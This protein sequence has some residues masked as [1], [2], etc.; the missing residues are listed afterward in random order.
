MMQDVIVHVPASLNLGKVIDF[1]VQVE[2]G[3][4]PVV[5]QSVETSTVVLCELA[6]DGLV[7]VSCHLAAPEMSSV[8]VKS[9]L[10]GTG[11]A[12]VSIEAGVR[13][14]A[15]MVGFV[16]S[17]TEVTAK[18]PGSFGRGPKPKGPKR[19]KLKAAS[20]RRA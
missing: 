18:V 10:T 1:A 12:V 11:P 4:M 14:K 13:V 20:K 19:V 5:V 6:P 7:K 15:V 17:T 9:M 8:S 3:G 2:V 16:V